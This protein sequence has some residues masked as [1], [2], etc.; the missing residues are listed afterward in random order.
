M[1]LPSCS[2]YSV[3]T[4]KE[5]RHPLAIVVGGL[6]TSM[7]LDQI[8]TPALFLKFSGKVYQRC[9]TAKKAEHFSV[10][11]LAAEFDG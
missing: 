2:P 1:S 4:G 9:A 5:I 6:L 11:D 7:L 8:V 3:Q 10:N